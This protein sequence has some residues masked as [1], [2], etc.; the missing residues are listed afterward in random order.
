MQEILRHTLSSLLG[1]VAK[2]VKLTSLVAVEF[3][4]DAEDG[5]CP[6]VEGQE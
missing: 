1:E 5:A 6:E 3:P 2:E 4:G